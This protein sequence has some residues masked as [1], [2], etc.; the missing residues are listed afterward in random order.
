MRVGVFQFEPRF[1]EIRGNTEHIVRCLS[2]VEADLIVLPEL[3]TTGYQFTSIE[4]LIS[5]AEPIAQSHAVA[6]ITALCR[7]RKLHI[8][9]GMAET[10]GGRHFNSA[11][12]VGPEGV[13]CVY[14]KVHLFFEEK[15]FFSPGEEA[16]PV[17][18]VGDARIGV[19]V[20]F[21][22][23][24]PEVVRVLTLKG[25]DVVCQPAN[26]VLPY[27]QDAMVTRSIENRVFTVTANRIGEESR[28]GKDPL[29]FSGMSQMVEPKGIILFRL[30]KKEELRVAEIDPLEAR[31]KRI[32]VH[33]DLI[34]D[35]VPAFYAR[36][37]Q[38]P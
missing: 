8:I 30:E 5:L 29:R 34:G 26:L 17:F 6:E 3:C 15:F 36:L 10:S 7:R 38:E 32:T 13:V 9:F 21:D 1:G 4:E 35:R 16:F 23:V 18:T 11:V 22:W 25:A 37:V 27:C 19:M 20:C 24:F 14:R 28:G 12:C 31:D 33:N 2:E